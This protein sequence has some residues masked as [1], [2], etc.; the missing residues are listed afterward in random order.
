MAQSEVIRAKARQLQGQPVRVTLHNGETYIGYI[1]NCYDKGVVLAGVASPV[2]SSSGKKT[3]SKNKKGKTRRQAGS[4]SRGSSTS[5][6][7]KSSKSP[8]S[9]RT[10]KKEAQVSALFPMLGSLFGGFGGLSGG[11]KLFGM[12]QRVF[13]V[14]KM[15]Y[16]MI[17]SISPFVGAVKGLM[18]PATVEATDA[19]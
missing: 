14:I 13:P 2:P 11:L 1:A 17:K 5:R 9:L 7:P 16:G 10:R 4:R 18:A 3:H 15:G 12:I 6:L 8:Y 19:D